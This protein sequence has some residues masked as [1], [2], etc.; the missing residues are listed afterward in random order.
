LSSEKAIHQ[1][2]VSFPDPVLIHTREGRVLEAN[3]GAVRSIA[4][5]ESLAGVLLS[6]LFK[7]T[8]VSHPLPSSD[9]PLEYLATIPVEYE[10]PAGTIYTVLRMK[11]IEVEG[12][13]LG[14]CTWHTFG[15]GAPRAH[16]VVSDS[17]YYSLFEQGHDAVFLFDLEGRCI[18]TNSRA[19]EM[20]GYS[21][22]EILKLSYKDLSAE[23][24][25]SSAIHRAL[26]AGKH[27][28]P[29]ERV[30]RKKNGDVF[31]AEVNVEVVRDSQRQPLY[32]QSMMRDISERKRAENTIRDLVEDQ[33][34]LLREVYH[35]IKNH[36][37]AIKNMMEVES[38]RV[39]DLARAVFDDVSMRIGSVA[40]V[41]DSLFASED[42]KT[43]DLKQYLGT[44]VCRI[45]ETYS[46]NNGARIDIRYELESCRIDPDRAFPLGIIVNE[47][48]TNAFKHAFPS[49]N[50]GSVS[51]RCARNGN[52]ALVLLVSDDGVGLSEPACRDESSGFGSHL[53]D[54]L[55]RQLGGVVQRTKSPGT[56][57]TVVVP[58]VPDGAGSEAS[59]HSTVAGSAAV[60]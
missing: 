47:L 1:T 32:L 33:Q 35:R 29:Y 55:T 48:V 4:G 21:T 42:F 26:L 34:L 6:D 31:P 13:R 50:E 52:D 12:K 49:G 36:L 37:N 7:P 11:P 14:F 40:L 2:F 19:L 9:R 44:L 27:I 3:E 15:L 45:A 58:M 22:D 46:G 30:L 51:I 59:H 5:R 53:V 18:E 10:S 38:T 25:E 16:S 60:N 8:V 23:V 39:P 41:Y 24:E 43:V 28:P 17:R 54:S 56:T 57:V 20:F